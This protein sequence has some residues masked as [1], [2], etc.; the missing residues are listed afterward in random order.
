MTFGSDD[1]TGSGSPIVRRP[2]R[3][4]MSK[5]RAMISLAEIAQALGGTVSAGQVRAPG[6]GHRPQDRSLSIKLSPLAHDGFVVF[7]HAGDD[8]NEC[9]ASARTKLPLPPC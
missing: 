5:G 4:S 2:A 8:V 7:S 1:H 3:I 9:P 6:P